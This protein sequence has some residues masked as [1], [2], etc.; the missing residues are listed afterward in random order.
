MKTARLLLC[1][2]GMLLTAATTGFGDVTNGLVAYYKLNGNG[3]DS[4]GSGND[5]TVC[6]QTTPTPDRLGNSNGAL[7]FYGDS[8]GTGGYIQISDAPSLHIT[9][10]ITIAAWVNIPVV[11]S[12]RT[13]LWKHDQMVTDRHSSSYGLQ[14]GPS[15]AQN[16][17]MFTFG[18]NSDEVTTGYGLQPGVWVHIAATFHSAG[19]ELR[20][21]RNGEFFEAVSTTKNIEVTN[22]PLYIHGYRYD[23]GTGYTVCSYYSVTMDEVRIYNRALSDAEVAE[24]CGGKPSG[25]GYCTIPAVSVLP[26]TSVTP[27]SAGLNGWIT[28]DGG[29]ACQ[30]R[31]R[32]KKSGGSY[33]YT[34]W[35][36]S[37]RTGDWFTETISGLQFGATYR[38]SAQARNSVIEGDW[39]GERSFMALPPVVEPKGTPPSNDYL[40]GRQ[41]QRSGSSNDPVNTATGNFTHEETD[42]ALAPTRGT[43][44]SF[45]RFYN[46]QDTSML[47]TL[48]PGWWHSY[49]IHLTQNTLDPLTGLVSVK[50]A[51]GRTD[52]WKNRSDSHAGFCEPQTPGLYD[53]L[54]RNADWT[55]TVTTKDLDTYYFNLWG[56]L[57]R[58]IDKNGN[59]ITLQ[60]NEPMS[61]SAV[62][63]VV[64]PSGRTFSFTYNVSP[65]S[66]SLLLTSIRDNGNPAR[67]VSY[68]YTKGRLTQVTDVM[69]NR[70]KYGYDPNGHLATVTD[71][72]GVTT[73][74]NVYDSACRVVEQTDGNGNTTSFTYDSPSPGNT[75]ITDALDNTTIHLHSPDW[76]LLLSIQNAFGNSIIY[77]YDAN[78]NRSA[79]TDRNGHSTQF[80]Y[81]GRGHVVKKTDPDDPCDPC[82][83]GVTSVRHDNP[84]LPDLPTSQ[85]DPLGNTTK[86]EYDQHGNLTKQT[87]PQGN[88]HLWTYN[89]FGQRLSETD[90]LNNTTQYVYDANGLL[91]EV[92]DPLGVHMWYGYDSLWRLTKVTDGRGASAGDPNHTVATR[93]DL[94]DRVVA[95]TGPITSET[96][97]YDKVGNRTAV[98]NGRGYV[99][100]S[101]YD[102]NSNLIK[103]ERIDPCGPSQVTQFGY[104]KVNRKV[105]ET[106]PNG[107]TTTSDYDIAGRLARVTDA[108]GNQTVFIRDAQGNVLSV[109]DGSSVRTCYEYDALDRKVHQYNDMGSH[110]RWQYD[111]LGRLLRPTNANGS[112]TGYAYDALG[113]LLSVTDATNGV[114]QYAYDL[115]GRLTQ[116]IDASGKLT[117]TRTYDADGRLT[118]KTDG[119]GNAYEYT[120][121]AV[122]SRISEKDANGQV[123]TYTYDSQNRLARIDYP[124]NRSVNYTYD[125]NGNR[126]S[127]VDSTGTTTFSH[128]AFDRLI[129]S[130]D[131]F[132]KTVGYGY[133]LA[134]NRTTLTYPGDAV[135]P[136]RTVAYAYDKANRLD[137]IVDWDSRVWDYTTDGAG[138]ITQ[139]L[140]PNGITG[141]RMYDQ[142]GRLSS[143]AYQR[144]DGTGLMGFAYTYDGQGNPTVISEQGTLESPGPDPTALAY[145]YD[146]QDRLVSSTGPAETYTYD[147]SSNLVDLVTDSNTTAFT[148]DQDNRLVSSAAPA[149]YQY[150][151]NGNLIQQTVQGIVTTFGFNEDNLLVSQTQG[152]SSVQ[153]I[154]D[155]LG[156]RVAR[157]DRGSMTRY[158]LDRGRGM[159]HVLCET[160][161]SGNIT[162]YYIHGPEI[163]GRIGAD[164]SQRF[165]LTNHIG[166]VVALT[167]QTQGLTDRY[168]YTPYGVPTGREG[169]TPNPFTYVGGLGVMAEN[170][171]FYFMRARFY[172]SHAGRFLSTD[173]VAGVVQNP[174]SFHPYL[175]GLSNSMMNIDPSGLTIWS[176][177]V[178]GALDIGEGEALPLAEWDLPGAI[179]GLSSYYKGVKELHAGLT[180]DPTEQTSL[181]QDLSADAYALTSLGL[182]KVGIG[183]GPT[184]QGIQTALES[185]GVAETA[186]DLALQAAS[187]PTGHT[188]GGGH[189]EFTSSGGQFMSTTRGWVD[190]ASHLVSGSI[191]AVGLASGTVSLGYQVS[192]WQSQTTVYSPQPTSWDQ[193][194]TLVSRRVKR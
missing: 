40:L 137:K 155:G 104:D 152:D 49:Q 118:R 62:S 158:V 134:G 100:A 38:F 74:A 133:D 169:T 54:Y 81:D 7:D 50:W 21:Y 174:M 189:F 59:V 110:W 102:N 90:E 114:T 20:F 95:V 51:D 117:E 67:V 178:S 6:G 87:D 139:M 22:A 24:I 84:Q 32:Y 35:T 113:R 97:Q 28:Y 124:G 19:Q 29:Q 78:G 98:T 70:V 75:A 120:Y 108:E 34:S 154:Y 191:D 111:L 89:S 142:A 148:Y 36:G 166:T 121:D 168:A 44:L 130:T 167:D 82:D 132:G 116:I 115:L 177:V 37:V 39:C 63:A 45:V 101:T 41:T 47:R 77:S 26:A 131:G 119:L 182:S 18:H 144:S 157:D 143:L 125:G 141:M 27:T 126:L 61:S 46:S 43:P 64:D 150:D 147:G 171:G 146:G 193:A 138:R 60:Y 31:F 123:K 145:T 194:P 68:S 94:A 15:W 184:E 42:L 58:I 188:G 172:D 25:G 17:V 170:D 2:I 153:H 80:E 151:G 66:A 136:A 162:A 176:Q 107:Y 33:H 52:Y 175:Y 76:K 86:W 105:S 4:S 55:W 187:S 135:H 103:V 88:T 23:T 186:V 165:Y 48:G 173:L 73:V 129:S 128:D 11:A 83:G 179:W 112:T 122:G 9:P 12:G 163:V 56:C 8:S 69:G 71:Q 1:S 192:Q 85:T 79:I 180:N 72:R 164:D 3:T 16:E 190:E 149:T 183:Q 91:A 30:Y 140:Y 53:R 156:T 14:G 161:G 160:D 92:T 57:Q 13:F 127:M 93:Y 181:I 96:Y 185:S 159:S 65:D 106:T 5:G 109:T 10:D 99:T